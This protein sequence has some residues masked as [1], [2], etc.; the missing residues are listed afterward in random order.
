[1]RPGR[2]PLDN[3]KGVGRSRV[4]ASRAYR[5]C[6]VRERASAKCNG[7][8]LAAARVTAR[9]APRRRAHPAEGVRARGPGWASPRRQSAS[10]VTTGRPKRRLSSIVLLRMIAHRRARATRRT[11]WRPGE[12]AHRD[13][14][15][16][17]RA[18]DVAASRIIA[19]A[20]PCAL[21]TCGRPSS[22]AGALLHHRGAR[23]CRRRRRW[24]MKP[25]IMVGKLLLRL[26]RIDRRDQV[27]LKPACASVS[28]H[29]LYVGEVEHRS[30]LPRDENV[31]VNVRG[32]CRHRSKEE[33]CAAAPRARPS[34]CL[35]GGRWPDSR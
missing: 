9:L 22:G 33:D 11:P 26:Q 31:C 29:L 16:P 35:R 10:P 12:G 28:H 30:R 34:A 27:G 18:A 19:P 20:S 4:G 5:A 17:T 14:S 8:P 7:W 15:M 21:S 23:H 24:V 32:V 2:A 3:G 1:M 6:S 25:R 13:S